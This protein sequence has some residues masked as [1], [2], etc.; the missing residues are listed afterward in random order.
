MDA[1][2]AD[3]KTIIHL[4]YKEVSDMTNKVEDKILKAYGTDGL[5]LLV[6]DNVPDFVQKRQALLPLG[7]K[8]ANLPK[9]AR[10]R[11]EN[12]AS[13]W[14]IGWSH[15]KE[16]FEGQPDYS[17]GSFYANP[18]YD[19]TNKDEVDLPLELLVDNMW[20]TEDLPELEGAF[21]NLGQQICDV[22]CMLARHIDRMIE[23]DN[24]AYTKGTMEDV[25][26]TSQSCRARLLHY[27]PNEKFEERPAIDLANLD[28]ETFNDFWCGWHNDHGALTGLCGAMYTDENDNLVDIK[29]PNAGLFI[30]NRHGEVVKGA[31]PKTSLAFQIGECGQI[32]SGG[33]LKATPHAV[34]KGFGE[35]YKNV[36]RNTL[37][38]FMQPDWTRKVEMPTG[39]VAESVYTDNF[40]KVPALQDRYAPTDRFI[41]FHSKT[42]AAYYPE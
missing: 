26:K 27:Y 28:V 19:E 29:D 3:R 36:S 38:V 14:S 31:F 17:K 41:D 21:K 39:C 6:V 40:S 2:K 42:I 24:P 12:E 34:F 1:S 25:I 9:E 37:A 33:L 20:P 13:K 22:G 15:G 10:D 18:Q 11:L 4:D 7:N 8:L 35:K 30:R 23:N 32:Y 16:K 5:G